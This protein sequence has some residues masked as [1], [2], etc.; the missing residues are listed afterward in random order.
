MISEEKRNG[1]Y[2]L[3]DDIQSGRVLPCC[4]FCRHYGR[5][6]RKKDN[7]AVEL[8]LYCRLSGEGK[9]Q[10]DLCDS[11]QGKDASWEEENKSINE[12]LQRYI[13]PLEYNGIIS[14]V[15]EGLHPQ[16]IVLYTVEKILDR[17]V[18]IHINME[19][20]TH[21]ISLFVDCKI[22]EIEGQTWIQT[23]IPSPARCGEAYGTLLE[24]CIND[25]LAEFKE[26]CK[27]K[28]A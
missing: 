14:K 4:E 21:F 7:N 2:Q 6:L 3:I 23:C 11:F 18:R 26:F 19:H 12:Y 20:E 13:Q 28:N 5:T 25:A 17:E 8:T 22:G 9:G 27:R 15:L 1:M 16:Q 10:R 24:N